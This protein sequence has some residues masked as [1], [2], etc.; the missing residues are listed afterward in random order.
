MTTGQKNS[1]PKISDSLNDAPSRVS[2]ADPSWERPAASPDG[3]A[4][5]SPPAPMAALG[6]LRVRLDTIRLYGITQEDRW[7]LKVYE[8]DTAPPHTLKDWLVPDRRWLWQGKTTQASGP[9]DW[10]GQ[11]LVLEN[12][13]IHR[14]IQGRPGQ[15]EDV[16]H[17]KTELLYVITD[18]GETFRFYAEQAT[19]DLWEK[20]RELDKYFFRNR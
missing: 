14:A 20:C 4:N 10:Q 1:S 6:Q 15:P 16:I 11:Q 18:Q 9:E 19:F 17:Q 12:G 5:C 13:Q 7:Q 8:K 3:E 2:P